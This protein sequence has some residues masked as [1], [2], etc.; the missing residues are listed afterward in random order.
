MTKDLSYLSY[1][2][3]PDIQRLFEAGD[4]D[5]MARVIRQRLEDPRVPKTLHERLRFQLI[6]AKEIPEYYR[7]T[8]ADMLAILQENI[9]D[10]TEDELEA[11]RDDGTLDWRYINGEV[12]FR[13]NCLDALLKV[14]KEYALR[15]KNPE[16]QAAADARGQRLNAMITRMKEEGGMHVRFELHEEMT[17]KS[18]RLTPGETLHIHL[19]LPVVG[20]QV[21]SAALL[22]TSHPAAFIAPADE[23]Q[24]TVY[25]ELP[26]EPGMTVSAELAYE[27]EA[28][29]ASRMPARFW[30]SSRRLTRRKCRRMWSLRRI[31]V[32]WRRKSSAMK[33]IRCSRRGRFTI[34]SPRRRSIATCRRI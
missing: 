17:V 14:R 5:R 2:L 27:I 13:N 29:T 11:L 21:K 30:R 22:S 8:Q 4:F 16:V 34:S 23:P 6:I 33:R 3:P 9:N 25:F 24:R 18:D 26:Y 19:P 12:H 1:P 7:L 15:A 20:A 31:C 28:P 32:R 10:F